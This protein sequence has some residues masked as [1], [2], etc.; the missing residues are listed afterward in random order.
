MIFFLKYRLNFL[1]FCI[2]IKI[3]EHSGMQLRYLERVWSS[4]D[5]YLRVSRWDKSSAYVRAYYSLLLKQNRSP[6]AY[7]PTRFFQHNCGQRHYCGP[8]FL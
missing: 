4:W 8:C 7:K 3:I 1:V 6:I 2:L 5:L